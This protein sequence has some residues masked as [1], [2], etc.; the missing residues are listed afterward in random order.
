MQIFKW[1]KLINLK[2]D[3][4]EKLRSKILLIDTKYVDLSK[5]KKNR[6]KKIMKLKTNSVTNKT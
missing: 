5:K 1:L 3:Q 4:F 6:N 2:D